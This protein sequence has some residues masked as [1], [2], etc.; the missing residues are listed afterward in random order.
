M[1]L[2]NL[3][4]SALFWNLALAGEGEPP[5]GEQK[6]FSPF[7]PCLLPSRP[8]ANVVLIQK[9]KCLLQVTPGKKEGERT[10]EKKNQLDYN[11]SGFF[12]VKLNWKVLTS[13]EMSKW[14]S[15]RRAGGAGAHQQRK[16][17]LCY[18]KPASNFWFS[19]RPVFFVCLFFPDIKKP[20]I[21]RS[22]ESRDCSWC[23][24]NKG[25]H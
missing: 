16:V 6:G 1:S 25:W 17:L 12:T 3:S 8:W 2:A 19:S 18:S 13:A 4:C 20:V 14:V 22:Q 11:L 10:A 15:W 23:A 5:G 24:L 21:Q 7:C 9:Y